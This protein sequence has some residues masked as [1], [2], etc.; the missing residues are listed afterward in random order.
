MN[1]SIGVMEYWSDE[2]IKQN[3]P[4]LKSFPILQHSTTPLLQILNC[5]VNGIGFPTA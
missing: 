4:G 1:W 3:L 5:I 2:K